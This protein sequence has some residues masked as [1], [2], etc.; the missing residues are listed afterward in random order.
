MRKVSAIERAQLDL[1]LLKLSNLP[2]SHDSKMIT[3]A[4]VLGDFYFYLVNGGQNP[5]L[6]YHLTRFTPLVWRF[7]G[8]VEKFSK[9]IL[10][11]SDI[12]DDM[13]LAVQLKRVRELS[14]VVQRACVYFQGEVSKLD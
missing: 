2:K 8:V 1:G 3:L 9:I 13:M 4:C 14:K 12:A 7:L 11:P 6:D 10:F 5:G